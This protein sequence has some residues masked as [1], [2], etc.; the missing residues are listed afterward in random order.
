MHAPPKPLRVS[1]VRR[2]GD[3]SIHQIDY[4]GGVSRFGLR[5]S[6]GNHFFPVRPTHKTL[7]M[8]ERHLISIMEQGI[9]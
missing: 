6:T 3:W 4:L 8:A 5:R 9:Q 7:E 1:E 2:A